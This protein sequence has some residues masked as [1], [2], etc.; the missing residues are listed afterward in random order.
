MERSIGRAVLRFAL[1]KFL[2][3]TIDEPPLVRDREGIRFT[4]C[5]TRVV[6][7]QEGRLK[8]QLLLVGGPETKKGLVIERTARGTLS[9]WACSL[10]RRA[11]TPDTSRSG[12]WLSRARCHVRSFAGPENHVQASCERSW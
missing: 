10:L 6:H 2:D 8:D 7:Q 5:E 11:R 3:K 4:V 12:A 9:R 1:V